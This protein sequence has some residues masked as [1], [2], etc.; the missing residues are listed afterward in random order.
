MKNTYSTYIFCNK[1]NYSVKYSIITSTVK[2][3]ILSHPKLGFFLI[4]CVYLWYNLF[5]IENEKIKSN[6]C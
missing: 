6:V 2:L 3:N 4:C 1:E 5:N